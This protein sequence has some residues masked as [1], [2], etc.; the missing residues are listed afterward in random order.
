MNGQAHTRRYLG[1]NARR[2]KHQRGISLIELLVSMAIALLVLAGV[3][4]T[5]LT[6]KQ[7]YLYNE[8]LA[9]IQENARFA[10]DQMTREIRL[11]GYF[12]CASANSSAK[13]ANTVPSEFDGLVNTIGLQG[14]EG[15]VSTFPANINAEVTGGTD[16]VII[17]RADTDQIF[18]ITGHNGSSAQIDLGATHPFQPGT[19]WIAAS[20]DC[21]H[22]GIFAQNSPTNNNGTVS[23]VVHNT[24]GG[25]N[26]FN[27]VKSLYYAGSGNG[28]AC[29][30]DAAA[31][32]EQCVDNSTGYPDGSDV[33]RMSGKVFYIAPSS[34]DDSIPALYQRSL[35]NKGET[36]KQELVIGVEDLQIEYG[37]DD[38]GNGRIERYI[39]AD[40]I[41]NEQDWRKVG[42]V[43]LQLVFR[44]QS[45]VLPE[46]QARQYLGVNYNDR[47]LRQVVST[48]VQVRNFIAG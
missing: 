24:G 14:F 32:I 17:R 12:G 6:S 26:I 4:Q 10:L 33:M 44:S 34:V 42:T 36:P 5:F 13:V 48:T 18:T 35:E 40:E 47:F 3:V 31:G 46:A 8:Q 22:I 1:G 9:F 38:D 29:D 11:A 43:R 15:G 39:S 25:Q 28:C 23:N 2:Q 27:C 19:I 41:S 45:P 7:S 21:Q 30:A 37:L 20:S 16:A